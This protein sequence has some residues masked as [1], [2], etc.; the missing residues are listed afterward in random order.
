MTKI[1][2]L[3]QMEKR[4][5]KFLR[6]CWHDGQYIT[7]RATEFWSVRSEGDCL[8]GERK[9]MGSELICQPLRFTGKS[10]LVC[11]TDTNGKQWFSWIH[12]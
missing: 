12:A 8:A 1:E 10:L 4:A 5:V 9:T 3:P 11:L 2:T 7:E 6:K